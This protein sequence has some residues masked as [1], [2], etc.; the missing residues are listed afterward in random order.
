MD[1]SVL[2][3]DYRT[4]LPINLYSA[5][6]TRA[7]DRYATQTL[8]I[9]GLLLMERAGLSC[10]KQIEANWPNAERITILCG[11]G[12]NGGDG[13]VIAALAKL[14]GM[15][16]TVLQ[17]G[18]I[19]KLRGDALL[20]QQRAN[21]LGV[22][23]CEILSG[24]ALASQQGRLESSDI[25][26]DALLGTGI[27]GAPRGLYAQAI[28]AINL[29]PAVVLAVDTPSGLCVNTGWV[30]GEAVKAQLTL[31]FIACKQ[32]LLTGVAA[33]HTGSLLFDDLRV[34]QTLYLQEKPSSSRLE[35]ENI[36]SRLPARLPT[37]HKGSCGH[38][39][40]IGGAEG[41][42]GAAVM[43][44]TAAARVGAGLVSIASPSQTIALQAVNQPELM[45]RQA[46]DQAELEA[47]IQRATV[48]VI[49]PGLG[50]SEWS[51]LALNLALESGKPCVVDADA[52]NLFSETSALKAHSLCVLT[53]HPKE[54]SRLLHCSTDAVQKDRFKAV[55]A[56]AKSFGATVVLKGPGTLISDGGH[57]SLLSAGGPAMASGGMGDVLSGVVGGLMAQGCETLYAAQLGASLHASAADKLAEDKGVRGILATDLIPL[58][59]Q[60]LQN[61]A[62]VQPAGRE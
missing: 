53:P 11:H 24:D 38:V 29:S 26:V 39:L 15:D 61:P 40:V 44:A 27:S 42:G 56:M 45:C 12:N 21:N 48:L 58:I 49:G 18:S 25:V 23:M 3:S 59:Q 54:A 9:A 50:Q 19:E 1:H 60:L 6:Q 22:P 14:A 55:D 43:A 46:K 31:T 34:P 10:F 37:A 52:L 2:D 17:L 36:L 51:L 8:G 57:V 47:L 13:Y 5:E 32:G 41:M 62:V 33:D 7:L 4:Q 28:Q 30:E 16:V 35:L 20:C